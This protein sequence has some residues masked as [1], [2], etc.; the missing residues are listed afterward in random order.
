MAVGLGVY[1]LGHSC[2]LFNIIV[3]KQIIE[4]A[5]SLKNNV[6]KKIVFL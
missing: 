1:V 3:E 4:K 5:L 6:C 2:C